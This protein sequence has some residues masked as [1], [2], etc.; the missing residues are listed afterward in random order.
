MLP[1][2]STYLLN[3]SHLTFNYTCNFILLNSP[4]IKTIK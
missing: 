2:I 4:L 1:P 3:K